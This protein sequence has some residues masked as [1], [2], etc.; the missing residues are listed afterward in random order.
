MQAS[1]ATLWL[2]SVLNFEELQL[3]NIVLH[4]RLTMTTEVALDTT[5]VSSVIVNAM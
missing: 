2:P 1:D 5:A 4:T 3:T